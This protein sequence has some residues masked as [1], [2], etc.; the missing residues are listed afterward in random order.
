[1]AAARPAL[2]ASSDRGLKVLLLS[3]VAPVFIINLGNACAYAFQVVLA[4]WLPPADVG[5]FN[6]LLAT[7]TLLTAPAAVA[8]LAITR[9]LPQLE[10]LVD[11]G[12]GATLVART[13]LA[14]M[15]VFVLLAIVTL[16]A[17]PLTA[18][19]FKI[20]TF[21]TFA[22]FASMMAAT[23]IYPV[24]GGWFQ[25]SGRYIGMA[26][27]LGGVPILRFVLGLLL[28][29][30]AGAGLN[31]AL[32]SATLPCLITFATALFVVL[33]GR[34]A[35]RTRLPA[36]VVRD[37]IRFVLPAAASTT[38]IY[39]LFNLDV[40]L[41]RAQFDETASGLYSVA[42]VIARI[43]FL[44]PAA[45]A[46]IFFADVM[47]QQNMTWHQRRGLLMKNLLIVAAIALGLATGLSV[48]AAPLLRLIAGEVYTASSSVLQISSFAMAGLALLNI[49][50]TFGMACDNQ[51]PFAVLFAGVTMFILS[52]LTATIT[53]AISI[54]LLITIWLMLAASLA[55]VLLAAP[56]TGCSA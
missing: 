36:S 40:M 14:C 11:H 35:W 6:A 12:A 20:D 45:L 23:V 51:K 48:L 8:P 26:L 5:A 46:G 3:Y 24:A 7:V 30:A 4:R 31:G 41:V 53:V 34:S 32:A 42:A 49:V 28:V 13:A 56:R 50:V 37:T 18:A 54:A 2:S 25:A 10:K 55:V 15:A 21:T 38:L 19:L 39:A 9:M 1:M 33:P 27:I 44:L 17:S 52:T 43:P 29:I 16:L 22:W 47:R